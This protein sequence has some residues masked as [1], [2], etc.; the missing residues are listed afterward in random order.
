MSS[1]PA[2]VAR[3]LALRHEVGIN[4]RTAVESPF[5]GAEVNDPHA[6]VRMPVLPETSPSVAVPE[7]RLRQFGQAIMPR[8]K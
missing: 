5:I 2:R 1:K 8:F 4:P 3:M 6:V 7:S